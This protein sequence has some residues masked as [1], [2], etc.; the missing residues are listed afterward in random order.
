MQSHY[1]VL[2]TVLL[3]ATNIHTVLLIGV[4]QC[5]VTVS[6]RQREGWTT[7]ED[8]RRI[9]NCA[10]R[11]REQM[12]C[13]LELFSPLLTDHISMSVFITLH[14]KYDTNCYVPEVWQHNVTSLLAYC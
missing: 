11:E 7:T 9:R 14:R 12:T 13:Q 5:A 3:Q 6:C 8:A 10:Q 1:L 4:G 2:C